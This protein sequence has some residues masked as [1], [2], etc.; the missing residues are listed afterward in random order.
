[1][2]GKNTAVCPAT[3]TH[4]IDDEEEA[5][6]GLICFDLNRTMLRGMLRLP[7]NTHVAD[8]GVAPEV[9]VA[10]A[11]IKVSGHEVAAPGLGALLVGEHV[12][13]GLLQHYSPGTTASH[14]S[15]S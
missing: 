1:M 7:A 10:D 12:H 11:N 2:D 13:P 6:P 5:K 15:A 14:R 3:E 8:L 4:C 9:V